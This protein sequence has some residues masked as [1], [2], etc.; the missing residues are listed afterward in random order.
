MYNNYYA[1]PQLV[2]VVTIK[3]SIKLKI[4]PNAF[5]D[6]PT[7][8]RGYICNKIRTKILFLSLRRIVMIVVF[9]AIFINILVILW[10]SLLFVEETGVPGKNQRHVASHWKPLSHNVVSSTHLAWSGFDLTT[11]VVI[12]TDCIGTMLL[13]ILHIV[14]IK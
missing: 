2:D 12:G 8:I 4:R 6:I 10:R 1:W 9:N 14:Y 3:T 5:C 11:L 7:I 13:R